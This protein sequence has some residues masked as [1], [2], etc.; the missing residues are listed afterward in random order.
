MQHRLAEPFA[1]CGQLHLNWVGWQLSEQHM[2]LLLHEVPAPAQ[3]VS[4]QPSAFF[5]S[6]AQQSDADEAAPPLGTHR[7]RQVHS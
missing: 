2:P 4:H 3:G 7:L 6:P 5:T 1:S